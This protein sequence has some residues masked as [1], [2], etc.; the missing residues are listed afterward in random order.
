MSCSVS[1]CS[2]ALIELSR[3]GCGLLDPDS[4]DCVAEFVLRQMNDDGGFRGRGEASDLY[5]TMFAIECLQA[6][7]RPLPACEISDFLTTFK[8]GNDLDLVHLSCLAR[9]LARLPET[10]TQR[11]TGRAVLRRINLL[12]VADGGYRLS[13][14]AAQDSIYACFLAV[15][16]HEEIGFEVPQEEAIRSCIDRLR[17]GDG[18]Y[19]DQPGLAS[20]TTTVTAAALALLARNGDPAPAGTGEWLMAR[21][22]RLGGFHASANTP[23]PDLLS[24]ATALF[25][26][27]VS[28]LPLHG[29]AEQALEFVEG[30]WD[31]SGGFAGNP[32]DP[33]ADCEYT[34]YGLLSLGAAQ[35]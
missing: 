26:L 9:C 23:A 7:D 6:L 1:S 20:G 29:I 31:D 13:C 30:L 14:D 4:A 16:A 22:G 25:A 34:Y 21:H 33:V 2:Q 11:E 32:L 5:Y 15:L 24:T 10:T 35:G 28:G 27:R 18:S 3:R 17:A 12:R 19:A 8:D